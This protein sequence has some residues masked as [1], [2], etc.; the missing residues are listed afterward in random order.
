M[1]DW[2][3]KATK[4]YVY[5][6]DVNSSLFGTAKD[7]NVAWQSQF[8]NCRWLS[9]GWTLQELLAPRVVEF[10]DQTGTLLGDKMSLEN[11]ICEATGIPAAALQGRPLTSYSIE[12]RLSWQR[13]RRTKKPEDAAYSLS[14]ICGVSMIPVYGEGQNRAMARL[15]KE[16]DDVFQGQ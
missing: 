3:A 9:R 13:N 12:E 6:S 14:G 7:C 1:F 4:C 16:I 10:Y 11:D 5:L 15:R 2:Y 8:R